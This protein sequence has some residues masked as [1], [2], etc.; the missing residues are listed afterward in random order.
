MAKEHSRKAMQA[1]R[2]MQAD[3]QDK[4]KL[5]NAAIAALPEH[6]RGPA[7]EDDVRLFPAKRKFPTDSPPKPGF[8]E[9]RRR[10]T[11]ELLERKTATAKRKSAKRKG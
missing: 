2:A 11:E 6:L 1:H 9:S 4:I 5:K 7:S 3:L 8:D 10:R